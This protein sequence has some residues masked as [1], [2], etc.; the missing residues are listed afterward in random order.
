[1]KLDLHVHIRRHFRLEDIRRAVK[2]RGLHGIAVTNFHNVTLA[3]YLRERIEDLLII[4]GQEVESRAGHILAIHIAEKIPDA[5]APEET[6]RQIHGQGGMA[7]LA[8][9]YLGWNSILPHGRTRHLA[10]DAVEAFNYRAGPMLYPNFLAQLG[11]RH[12]PWPG[13]A[14]TDSKELATIGR[15]Y[16]EVPVKPAAR[17]SAEVAANLIPQILHCLRQGEIRRHEE[18]QMPSWTW[19][20]HHVSH[21]LLPQK[22]YRCFYC[23]DN[24]V[25]KLISRTCTCLQCGRRQSRHTRCVRGHYV[26]NSCRTQQ[27]L[28]TPGFL[29]YREKLEGKAHEEIS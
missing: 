10:F 24:L 4:I 5:L 22:Y 15:C 14:N 16:N 20:G 9:P 21:L 25:F 12:L 23:G 3:R 8:H 17:Y 19:F 29:T 7:I 26:C 6:I 2:A 11:W 13:V 28:E 27:A 1:M 18:W